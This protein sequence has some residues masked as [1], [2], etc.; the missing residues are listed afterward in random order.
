MVSVFCGLSLDGFI[1]RP[2]DTLDFLDGPGDVG[3]HEDHGYHDFI[4]RID[5]LVM[6]RRTF[7]VVL[8]FGQ[9]PYGDLPVFVLTHRPLPS[10]LPQ[11]ANVTPMQGDPADIVAALE[12]RGLPRIYLDGGQTIQTFLADGFV[13]EMILT[14]L[15]VLI[16]QGISLFGPTPRDLWFRHHDTRVIGSMVQS[17]YRPR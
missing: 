9:W 13:D 12:A 14:R 7:D 4:A 15:P 1:A 16:G 6:G 2:D 5:A 8:S 17:T 10:D 3:S 11:G